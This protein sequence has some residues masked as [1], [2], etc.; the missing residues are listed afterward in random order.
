M[1][2]TLRAAVAGDGK[3]V[4]SSRVLMLAVGLLVLLLWVGVGVMIAFR[5]GT[6]EDY[7]GWLQWGQVYAFGT[8]G[9]YVLGKFG[10]AVRKNGD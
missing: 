1:T 2:G 10:S 5:D 9:N 8:F 6:W 7:S 3:N 4:S